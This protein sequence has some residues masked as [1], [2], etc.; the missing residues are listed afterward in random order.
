MRALWR[1]D[2]PS[3]TPLTY[4]ATFQVFARSFVGFVV[5]RLCG[6]YVALAPARLMTEQITAKE[7]ELG[8]WTKEGDKKDLRGRKQGSTSSLMI[9]SRNSL[10]KVALI[11]ILLTWLQISMLMFPW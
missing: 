2:V 5:R 6:G 7:E 8:L 11:S 3:H 4:E 9:T 10:K 1:V